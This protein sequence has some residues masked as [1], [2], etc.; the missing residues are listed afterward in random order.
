MRLTKE[1]LDNS[2]VLLHIE[3]EPPEMDKALEDSYKKIARQVQVPGFRKGKVPRE[4]L[5]RFVGKEALLKEAE[6]HAVTEYY[7]KAIEENHIEAIAQPKI[8][9]L[10]SDPVVAFRATVAVRP[11]VELGDYRSIRLKR[12]EV[13]VSDVD[14]DNA[15]EELRLQQAPWEPAERPVAFGDMVIM[16]AQATVEGD[17]VM[18]ETAVQYPV[19]QGSVV[20]V[21]GFAE[22]LQ[23][24]EKGVEKTFSISLPLDYANRHLAG[25]TMEF[26]VKVAEVKQKRIPNLDDEFAKSIGEGFDTLAQ[27]REKV[28]S[29]LK[30]RADIEARARYEEQVVQA[31]IDQARMDLPDV[32]VDRETEAIISEQANRFRGGQ[33]GLDEYLANVGKTNDQ[34]KEEMRPEARRRVV[35]ALVLDK[36]AEAEAINVSDEEVQAEVEAL[37]KQAADRADQV[38]RAFESHQSRHSL[39]HAMLN[40]KTISRLV[41]MASAEQP[42]PAPVE[43]VPATETPKT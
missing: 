5:E 40:R 38:R 33:K 31:A 28:L 18:N 24:V 23:G 20:P 6:E 26:K 19:V 10:H 4:I 3:L 25:K 21:P 29:N 9:V 43:Q 11:E 8:E 30:V 7:N 39:E 16:D 37:A 34:L 41:E 17:S 14:V 42:T 22:N 32:M 13:T 35:R 2:Q 1:K 36:I 15:L 27:L 12:E